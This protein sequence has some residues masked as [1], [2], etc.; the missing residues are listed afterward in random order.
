[1][2]YKT[3]DYVE[4]IFINEKHGADFKMPKNKKLLLKFTTKHN[5]YHEFEIT[6]YIKENYKV[7]SLSLMKVKKKS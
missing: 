1:M 5:R 2:G 6:G 4:L 7:R 3:P